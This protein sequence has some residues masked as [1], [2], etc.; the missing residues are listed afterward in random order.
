MYSASLSSANTY[1]KQGNTENYSLR[2]T[3]KSY[4]L[5]YIKLTL[6]LIFAAIK[7][8]QENFAKFNN[9]PRFKIFL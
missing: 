5:Y 4:I 7:L 6:Y 8:F 2:V 1:I 3:K 9:F